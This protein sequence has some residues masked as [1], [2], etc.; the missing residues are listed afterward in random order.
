MTARSDP[1][2]SPSAGRVRSLH[3]KPEMAGEHGLPKPTVN[4]VTVDARGVGHDFNRYRHE[5][6]HDA[7]DQAV[8]LMPVE[9]IRT[10][11]AEGWPIQEGDIGE[12]ITTEGI[13]YQ[14]FHPGDRFRIGAAV[15]QVTKPCTPCTNLHLLPYV[16]AAM[17]PGFVRT[18]VD[19]RGWYASVVHA[20][21][22]RTGD[23]IERA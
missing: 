23:R 2:S 10:L 21:R 4:E 19:R 3:R 16:G 20:G 11:N 1:P 5:D 12:N 22:I 13:P 15:L 17:G 8:L 7:A 14:E 9:M 6:L 18:M